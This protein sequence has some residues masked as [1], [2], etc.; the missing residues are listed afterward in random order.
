VGYYTQLHFKFFTSSWSDSDQ[1]YQ[2]NEIYV[3]GFCP[4]A[5]PGMQQSQKEHTAVYQKQHGIDNNSAFK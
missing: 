3:G 5:Q 1:Q 4:D 2:I